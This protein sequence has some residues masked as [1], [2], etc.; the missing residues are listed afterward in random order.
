MKLEDRPSSTAIGPFR[1]VPGCPDFPS[2]PSSSIEHVNPGGIGCAPFAFDAAFHKLTASSVN[3]LTWRG[4]VL[5]G[6]RLII[7]RTILFRNRGSV[8]DSFFKQISVWILTRRAFWY[9]SSRGFQTCG[10]PLRESVEICEDVAKPTQIGEQPSFKNEGMETSRHFTVTHQSR[11]KP[12]NYHLHDPWT[13][14]SCSSSSS[15]QFA[16]MLPAKSN[17]WYT[18]RSL[19]LRIP[20][21]SRRAGSTSY[22]CSKDW[23]HVRSRFAATC[24]VGQL[25]QLSLREAALIL[26]SSRNRRLDI[27]GSI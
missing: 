21:S 5:K 3:S 11:W 23:S 4:H 10:H 7:V 17:K 27:H 6:C 26:A 24:Y 12:M 16:I 9:A 18:L 2:T 1:P 8:Q 15:L 20:D 25:T 13:H 19:H 22:I 14:W